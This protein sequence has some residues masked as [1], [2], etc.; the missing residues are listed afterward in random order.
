MTAYDGRKPTSK[1]EQI[2]W[3]VDWAA[4]KRSENGKGWEG[5]DANNQELAE[6]FSEDNAI[7]LSHNTWKSR[8]RDAAEEAGFRGR[9]VYIPTGG[10]G[11][12]P[13]Y[14]MVYK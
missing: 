13:R 3:L 4:R 6:E 9:R 7:T 14:S 2:Q 8:I 1:K 10:Y 11:Y 5:L 12:I